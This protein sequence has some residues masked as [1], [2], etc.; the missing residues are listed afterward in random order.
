M[1][2][3]SPLRPTVT[4]HYSLKSRQT[5]APT[6]IGLFGAEGAIIR[7]PAERSDRDGNDLTKAALQVA[8]RCVC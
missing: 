4:C 3:P 7:G 8:V 6:V 1:I 2:I 5:H